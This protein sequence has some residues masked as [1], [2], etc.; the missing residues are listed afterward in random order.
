MN[1]NGFNLIFFVFFVTMGVTSNL[2]VGLSLTCYVS[3]FLRNNKIMCD[4]LCLTQ[5]ITNLV[6]NSIKF[7]EVGSVTVTANNRLLSNSEME[8][9]ITVEDTGIG[10]SPENSKKLFTEFAQLH[11]SSKYG[12]TGLGL[13]I[14]KQLVEMLG[15]TIKL[16]ST[17]GV[18]TKFIVT[19]TVNVVSDFSQPKSGKKNKLSH[20]R[21][22]IKP[23]YYKVLVVEDNLV[24]QKV[25]VSFM[26]KL[27]F[28]SDTATN[29]FEAIEM[30]K[31]NSYDLILMDCQMPMCDGYKATQQIRMSNKVIPIV[32]LTADV[33][34]ESK[35]R[36]IE[37]GMDDFLSK[38]MTIEKL[39]N[40]ISQ[41]FVI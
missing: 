24:N 26:R 28:Q 13:S 19:M 20:P 25:A 30:A 4:D 35:M 38:P 27:G 6:N 2:K 36:C 1:F 5:I 17:L 33:I 9:S 31:K 10:I 3:D 15:G 18:G 21:D 32:A 29:G 8:L 16:T 40:L 11:S 14:C 39:K 34:G 41:F 7:T 22:L 23:Q 12:G 37:A